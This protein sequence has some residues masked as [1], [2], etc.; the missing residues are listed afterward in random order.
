MASIIDIIPNSDRDPVMG[1]IWVALVT[2]PVPLLSGDPLYV[3]IPD[4]D[5]NTKWGPCLWKAVPDDIPLLGTYCLVM[6]D[7][8]GSLWVVSY[9]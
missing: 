6:F 9:Q 2:T 1:G 3:I 8:R 5:H 4:I 7:N